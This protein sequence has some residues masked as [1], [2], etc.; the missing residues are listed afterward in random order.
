MDELPSD[1]QIVFVLPRR[2]NLH[3][4]QPGKRGRDVNG[5]REK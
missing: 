1:Q 2:R 5:E 4:V 3:F